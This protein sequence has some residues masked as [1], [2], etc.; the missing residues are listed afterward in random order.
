TLH[1]RQIS[2]R[3]SHHIIE[4]QF[5]SV[6]RSMRQAVSLDPELAGEIPSTKGML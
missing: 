6:A 2:G 3:N 4:G 1:I 5:K